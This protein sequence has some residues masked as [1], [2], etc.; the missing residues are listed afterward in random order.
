VSN[1][2]NLIVV[3]AGD[4]SLHPQWL[5]GQDRNWDIVVSYYGYIAERYADQYDEIHFY[6]GSKWNGIDDFCQ[7][8][9]YIHDKYE[10]IWF[11][12]DDLLTQCDNINNFFDITKKLD[13]S[14][15]QPSLTSYSHYSWEITRQLIGCIAR[16]TDFVEIM[17]PC[18]QAK[19]LSVFSKYFGENSSGWGYEWL[20]KKLAI[21]N[22]IFKFGIIDA[23]PVYHTRPVG[24]AG[25]GGSFDRP[26]DE[27]IKL[28]QKYNLLYD[29]PQVLC[30]F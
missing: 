4:R 12:D 26:Q 18:F 15:S 24:S 13:F 2:K 14:I 5:S 9:T 20:W 16:Q 7:K 28:Q 23:T 10:Y 17:A 19:N 6:K 1:R 11:P 3:R 25:H 21:D 27:A 29:A 22:D 30:K 8:N